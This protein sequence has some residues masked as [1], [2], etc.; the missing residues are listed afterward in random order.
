MLKPT[1]IDI[2][3]IGLQM[4]QLAKQIEDHGEMGKILR[5]L[6]VM[7][8]NHQHANKM[9]KIMIKNGRKR[10]MKTDGRRFVKGRTVKKLPEVC[11]LV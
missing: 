9:P 6:Q 8:K 4:T 2:R 11:F 5:H 10:K 1:I 3:G 7:P